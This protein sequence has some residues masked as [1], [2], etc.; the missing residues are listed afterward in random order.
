MKAFEYGVCRRPDEEIYIKQRI[1]L[2]KNVPGL[3]FVEELIDVDESKFS[4][5]MHEKGKVVLKNSFF[6]NEVCI[7]S[8]FDISPYFE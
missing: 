3:T 2:L 4:I 5:M 1:L 6:L 8:D 7:E